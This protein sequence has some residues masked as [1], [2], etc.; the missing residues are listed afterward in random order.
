MELISAYLNVID[1]SQVLSAKFGFYWPS[2]PV[3]AELVKI[4]PVYD[5]HDVDYFLP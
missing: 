3:L 5:W 1:I 4:S 2:C